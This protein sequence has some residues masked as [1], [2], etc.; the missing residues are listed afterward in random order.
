[1]QSKTTTSDQNDAGRKI[2]K[3]SNSVEIKILQYRHLNYA[4]EVYTLYSEGEHIANACKLLPD[5]KFNSL[6]ESSLAMIK[7]SSI[8]ITNEELRLIAYKI[9]FWSIA[10]L[11]NIL[12]VIEK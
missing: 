10:I 8:S 4:N 3:S 7:F 6:F 2:H 5:E 1:M 11:Q 9:H 12:T